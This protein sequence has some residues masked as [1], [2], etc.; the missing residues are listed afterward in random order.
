MQPLNARG[1][2][3]RGSG[4]QHPHTQP[5][6]EP[7][8]GALCP[9][10]DL[11]SQKQHNVHTMEAPTQA[12]GAA[13]RAQR[14]SS[15][16]KDMHQ[17]LRT[18]I[19][20]LGVSFVLLALSTVAFVIVV[21]VKPFASSSSNQ[22]LQAG[23]ERAWIGM[24]ELFVTELSNIDPALS[25][26]LKTSDSNEW[27]ALHWMVVKPSLRGEAHVSSRLVQR[28]AVATTFLHFSLPL[29]AS[30][31]ECSWEGIDCNDDQ[32]V[33]A[34]N[35]TMYT[36]HG[37]IP[38]ALA[39]LESLESLDLSSQPGLKGGVPLAAYNAWKSLVYLDVHGSSLSWRA[40]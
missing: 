10:Q 19:Y 29:D 3:V 1:C 8:E 13:A 17:T 22:P 4:H 5:R 15:V 27:N 18:A 12:A 2:G 35:F 6:E 14:S 21:A 38:S 40:Y 28:F 33:L 11:S 26:Q 32:V 34:L 30:S 36:L 16:K 7:R 31:H 20:V 39:Y 24:R 25:S 9:R 23:D 37:G